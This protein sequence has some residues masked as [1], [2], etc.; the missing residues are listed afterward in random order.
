MQK[1]YRD[2]GREVSFFNFPK[3]N[4]IKKPTYNIC[5]IFF[6]GVY[7]HDSFYNQTTSKSWNCFLRKYQNYSSRKIRW[8]HCNTLGKA[9]TCF[10]GAEKK[11]L[12]EL[13]S[14]VSIENLPRATGN[15]LLDLNIK[16]ILNQHRKIYHQGSIEIFCKKYIL[17]RF[18]SKKYK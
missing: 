5:F 10:A 8:T 18:H 4:L 2:S 1:C 11:K 12:T 7:C 3:L 14:R 9:N 16:N 6:R 13:H 15:E 17:S